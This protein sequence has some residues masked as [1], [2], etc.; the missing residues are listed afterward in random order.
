MRTVQKWFEKFR[1]GD[2]NLQDEPR[3]R[4]PKKLDDDI[5]RALVSNELPL[6]MRKIRDKLS[7]SHITIKNHLI[8]LGFVYDWCRWI[9][10]ELSEYNNG[11]SN[12]YCFFFVYS[13]T[14]W[15]IIES[16]GYW[17]RK[18]DCVWQSNEEKSQG[19]SRQFASYSC[20][21]QFAPKNS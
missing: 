11:I 19:N 8:K 2:T 20:K 18:V 10:G 15:A 3:T 5:L 4:R 12:F 16:P 1:S 21:S 17:W 14:I 9:P 13:T 6:A 7:V